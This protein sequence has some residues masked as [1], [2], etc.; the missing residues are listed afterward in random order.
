MKTYSEA[1][2]RGTFDWLAAL[3]AKHISNEEWEALAELS[4]NWVTCACGN[5]CDTIPRSSSGVPKDLPLVT[6]SGGDGFHGAIKRQNRTLA[7]H[8]LELIEDR[9]SLILKGL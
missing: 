8:Y 3:T 4:Q 9:V 2:G 5:Q 1:K 7:L 6:L